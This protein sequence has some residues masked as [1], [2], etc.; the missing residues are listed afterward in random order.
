MDVASR[1]L[2]EIKSPDE[3]PEVEG[4]RTA[5]AYPSS[6]RECILKTL[7]IHGRESRRIAWRS[8]TGTG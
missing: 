3:I 2:K 1:K 6:I 4:P 8:A 5:K 7:A